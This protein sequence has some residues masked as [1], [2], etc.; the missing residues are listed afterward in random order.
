MFQQNIYVIECECTS[1]I[2][3]PLFHKV[4]VKNLF[5]NGRDEG[6]DG[7]IAKGRKIFLSNQPCQC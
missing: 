4:D 7:E 6:N 5:L 3:M 1:S 2:F